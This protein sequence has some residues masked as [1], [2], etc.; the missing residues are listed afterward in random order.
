MGKTSGRKPGTA[1]GRRQYLSE[2]NQVTN[3]RSHQQKLQQHSLSL[4]NLKKA[5]GLGAEDG[6]TAEDDEKEMASMF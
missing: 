1:L 5:G 3:Q 4:S 2:A 6:T